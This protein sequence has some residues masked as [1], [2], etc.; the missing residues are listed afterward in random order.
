MSLVTAYAGMDIINAGINADFSVS[1]S[2]PV[3]FKKDFVLAKVPAVLL[4]HIKV[5][6]GDAIKPLP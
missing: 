4:P 3:H 5:C 1:V 2:G 6:L